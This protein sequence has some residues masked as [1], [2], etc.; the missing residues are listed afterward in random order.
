M[1]FMIL[2]IFLEIQFAF[3]QPTGFVRFVVSLLHF[4]AEVVQQLPICWLLLVLVLCLER[5][6]WVL[7]PAHFRHS[8]LQMC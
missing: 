8:R 5:V 6:N 1:F 3:A 2:V 4:V 7:A